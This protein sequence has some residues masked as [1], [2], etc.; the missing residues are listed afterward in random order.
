MTIKYAWNAVYAPNMN[1]LCPFDPLWAKGHAIVFTWEEKLLGR[2]LKM[3]PLFPAAGSGRHRG[4]SQA[5]QS[6]E[7][8]E[9]GSRL[10]DCDELSLEWQSEDINDIT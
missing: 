6:G 3:C 8:G 9:E 5:R 10:M 4:Y 1:Y 2:L 7:A